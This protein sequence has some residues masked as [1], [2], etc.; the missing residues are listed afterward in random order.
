MT[1]QS[2]PV[3]RWLAALQKKTE[4]AIL[5]GDHKEGEWLESIVRQQREGDQDER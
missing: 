3:A 4:D 1:S 5:R 2:R